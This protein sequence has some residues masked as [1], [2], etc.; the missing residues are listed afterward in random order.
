MRL[1]VRLLTVAPIAALLALGTGCS[2]GR[3]AAEK[4]LAELR[5]EVTRLRAAQAALTERVDGLEIERGTFNKG[6]A[7]PG[8]PAGG[9]DRPELTTVRLSPSEGDGDADS[10]EPRPL[11]R[12]VG[13]DG[14]VRKGDPKKK[15]A[16]NPRK[17]VAAGGATPKKDAG[18]TVKP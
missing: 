16:P 15:D 9:G 14:S 2:A 11:I 8:A 12:A 5:A 10:G 4:E 7:P 3:D 18:S 17:G 1:S 6:A 13:N